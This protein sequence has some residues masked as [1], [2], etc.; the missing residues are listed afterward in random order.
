MTSH[1]DG[2][3]WEPIPNYWSLCE[4]DAEPAQKVATLNYRYI[5]YLEYI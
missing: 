5:I 3:F 2:V 1:V 4:G